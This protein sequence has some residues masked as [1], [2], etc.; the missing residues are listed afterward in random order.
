MHVKIWWIGVVFLCLCGCNQ[1]GVD[2]KELQIFRQDLA[3]FRNDCDR[4]ARQVEELTK[5][6]ADL[7]QQVNTPRDARTEPIPK[8]VP[9]R[10]QEAVSPSQSSRDKEPQRAPSLCDVI[11]THIAAVEGI[12]SQP[13][14]DSVET[15]LDDLEASFNA[16]LRRFA[17]HPRILQIREAASTMRKDF[18]AAAKQ[19]PLATNP[20]LKNVRQKSLNDARKAAKTLRALCEE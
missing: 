12:L 16:N 6:T 3:K 9:V 20:Y 19:S 8:Q 2:Q 13:D 15:L 11:E 18:L 17:N 1:F 5:V 10:E 7:R 4:L 14:S